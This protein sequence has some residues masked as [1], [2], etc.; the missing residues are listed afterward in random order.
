VGRR[1]GLPVGNGVGAFVVVVVGG[2]DG[3]LVGNFVG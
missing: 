2:L 3:A 1:V